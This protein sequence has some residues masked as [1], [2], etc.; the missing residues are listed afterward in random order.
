[1]ANMKERANLRRAHADAIQLHHAKGI[2]AV[3]FLLA[4]PSCAA[5]SKDY[6]HY[7]HEPEPRK[8][9]YVIGIGD[10][11][12]VNVWKD[13]DLSTEGHV[14]PDGSFTM[15]LVGE[16]EAVHLSDLHCQDWR[17]LHV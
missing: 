17:L 6:N 2:V 14:R 5:F 11:L 4:A 8:H 13:A 1:M 3:A 16:L 15:P 9:P 12:R 7:A 10:G